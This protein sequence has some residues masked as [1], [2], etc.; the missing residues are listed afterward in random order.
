[1]DVIR[2]MERAL[3]SFEEQNARNPQQMEEKENELRAQVA[4]LVT[5]ESE[6]LKAMFAR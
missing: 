1:M 2:K 3:Q 4:R 6:A 5:Q